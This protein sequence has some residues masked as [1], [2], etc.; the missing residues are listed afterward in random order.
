MHRWVGGARVWAGLG[1]RL[2]GGEVGG[3]KEIGSLE[4]SPPF[5]FISSR[6]ICHTVTETN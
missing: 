1:R 4:L 6:I 3:E 2:K 5:S